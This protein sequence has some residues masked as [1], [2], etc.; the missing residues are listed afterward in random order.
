MPF[1]HYMYLL[2]S[3]CLPLQ[4]LSY[5]CAYGTS[6]I[7]LIHYRIVKTLAV[8]SLA[9]KNYRKFGGKSFGE[10]KSIYIGNVM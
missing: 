9:N 7:P 3:N 2:S 5:R 4:T 1:L 8:K 6:N 10:L